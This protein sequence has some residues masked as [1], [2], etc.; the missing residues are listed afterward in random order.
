MAHEF[1]IQKAITIEASPEQVWEAIS[2]GPGIDS[3]FMGR[4]EIEPRTGGAARMTLPGWSLDSTITTW[5]PGKRYAHRSEAG[6]DGLQMAFEYLIEGRDNGTTVLRLV[7][8]G[9]LGDDWEAEY[10]AL[11]EGDFMYLQKLAAYL[12][13]FP[14]RTAAWSLFLPRPEVTDKD[15]AWSAFAGALDVTGPVREGDAVRLTVDGLP[16]ADGSV[17][18]ANSQAIGVRTG[19]GLYTLIYGQDTVVVEHHNFAPG[20]DQQRSEAAWQAW[21]TRAFG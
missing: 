14:G 1:E 5:E 7:H 20:A 17:V 16:A 13:F 10:D 11:N 9:F 3:W 12:K 6:P 21:L 19:D 4:S 15:R 18:L 8:S 2:T